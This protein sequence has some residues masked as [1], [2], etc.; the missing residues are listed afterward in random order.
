MDSAISSVSETGE[1]TFI[2]SA[3]RM[4]AFMPMNIPLLAGM[5]LSPPTM[6]YTILWQWLNQSYMAGLNYANKNPSSTYTNRDL[7]QGYSA[8][9]SA[10]IL[11]AMTL[12]KM[13]AGIVAR[14]SGPR[15]MMLNTMIAAV[16]SSS[17]G[18]VNTTLMR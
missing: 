16:A 1:P 18:Y 8:S 12:R 3:F 13:T 4:S 14:S 5:I 9:V 10:S 17:A 15:L 6:G 11:T 2:T 7:L